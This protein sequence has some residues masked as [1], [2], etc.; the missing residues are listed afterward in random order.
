MKTNTLDPTSPANCLD[1]I[2]QAV[3]A[4]AK[5]SEQVDASRIIESY[6]LRRPRQFSCSHTR[7]K[8]EVVE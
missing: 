7:T 1:L 2:N 4:I 5:K 3:Y 8:K 6:L